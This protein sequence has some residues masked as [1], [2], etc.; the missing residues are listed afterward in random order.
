MTS[1]EIQTYHLL[2]HMLFMLWKIQDV[3]DNI[4]RYVVNIFNLLN[5]MVV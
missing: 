5:F 4:Q 2:G 1:Y 3:L